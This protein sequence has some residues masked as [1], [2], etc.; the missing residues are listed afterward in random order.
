MNATSA[1]IEGR[2]WT[3]VTVAWVAVLLLNL[4][5]FSLG[6][7][8]PAMREELNF[9][10]EVAGYLSASSWIVKGIITIPIAL[11]VARISPRYVLTAVYCLA[12]LALLLQGNAQNL[13]MV[14]IGRALV[15]AAAAGI[16]SPLVPI[17][18]SWIP[19][20]K[21]AQVN[22]IEN[23]ISPVGQSL[24][25]VAVT[26]LLAILSGWRGVINTMGIIMI[27]VGVVFFFV[28]REKPGKEWVK[29]DVPFIEPLKD[30]LR[31]KPVW[32]LALGW[33]GTSLVW[34]ATYTFWPTYAVEN[35]GITMAQAGFVL[36]LLPIFSAIASLVS[37][38]IAKWI[39]YDKLMIWP[40][41]FILPLAYFGM[42]QTSNIAILSFCSALAGFGAYAFVP[43]AFTTLY[44]IPGIKPRTVTLGISC[45]LTMVG[46][47]SALG[48]MLAGVIGEAM[49]LYNGMA[50]CC[51]SPFL[52]GIL[53][54]FLPETGRKY[55][56]K[57]AAEAAK[58]E[59]K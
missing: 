21:I 5:N 55:Q 14:F 25:T 26:Y 43:V 39:G 38:T 33:P 51:L 1:K 29:S 48:G 57:L 42:L 16:L 34:I 44:R 20:D 24:G 6:M 47:G 3:M 7:M 23:F 17:K 40:W 18:I 15:N 37:P 8:L 2:A 56:E 27:V 13:M 45:I 22:G 4:A 53:T 36:G 49:G 28:Y 50:I 32:L 10:V 59:V 41:G 54:L 58:S 12:G 11:I 30:A 52:F 35:L 46:V 31:Y 19:K 9:G